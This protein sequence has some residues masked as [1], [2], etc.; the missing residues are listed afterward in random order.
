MLKA[1]PDYASDYC[2][3]GSN[4]DVHRE[5]SVNVAPETLDAKF[6]IF[7]AGWEKDPVLK[8]YHFGPLH[9]SEMPRVYAST[10]VVIDDANHVTVKSG[11]VNSRVFDAIAAGA[12][13][14]TNG[15]IGSKEVFDGALPTYSTAQEFHGLLTQYLSDEDAQGE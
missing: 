12:L 5:I 2:F 3:T 15:L 13:P 11:S 6:R 10:K 14:V 1:D 8:S 7:G 9:Y 4:W